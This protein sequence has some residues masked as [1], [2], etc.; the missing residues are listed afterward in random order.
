MHHIRMAPI[1]LRAPGHF[2]RNNVD[3]LSAQAPVDLIEPHG[4]AALRR[5]KK[6]GDDQIAL[7]HGGAWM[8]PR[9]IETK[10]RSERTPGIWTS[11]V[12]TAA[13]ASSRLPRRTSA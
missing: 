4:R 9:A 10:S 3:L 6:L 13:R 12:A 8:Q 1:M 11:E 5:Q 2:R 7:A